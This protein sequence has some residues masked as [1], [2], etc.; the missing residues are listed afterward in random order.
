[1]ERNCTVC[2]RRLAFSHFAA[3]KTG[4]FGL[5]ATC[6]DCN[7][8]RNEQ[9]RIDKAGDIALQRAQHR[10]RNREK[11]AAESKDWARKNPEKVKANCHR[12]ARLNVDRRREYN[13]AW[14]RAN[15]DVLRPYYNEKS[16]RRFAARLRASPEWADKKA[17]LRIYQECQRISV[18][19]GIL[20]H[21]DHIVPLVSPLVCGLHVEYNLQI[22]PAAENLSKSNKFEV[23][24]ICHSPSHAN[25][26]TV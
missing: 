20:H 21:V 7:A 6:R 10:E 18:E 17:V 12:Y 1:M 2:Q 4:R 15:A 26:R 24:T 25:F 19:T 8:K 16:R 11:L 3:K 23:Q 9:Y 13:A 22:L 14:Q 5:C